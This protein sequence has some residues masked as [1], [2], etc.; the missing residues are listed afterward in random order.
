M[1]HTLILWL[2]TVCM[3]AKADEAYHNPVD[4]KTYVT[5]QWKEHKPVKPRP[6]VQKPVMNAGIRLLSTEQEIGKNL[7]AEQL[8]GYIS[9]IEQQANLLIQEFTATGAIL[10]QVSLSPGTQA[11]YQMSFQGEVPKQ[12]LQKLYNELPR[13]TSPKVLVSNVAFQIQF[14]VDH[15]VSS[16]TNKDGPHSN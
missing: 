16:T 9:S 11:E 10:L 15:T 3:I 8:V 7:T 12:Y 13:L 6:K 4:G 14:N 2:L 5:D 1:K